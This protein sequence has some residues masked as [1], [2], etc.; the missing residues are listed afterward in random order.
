MSMYPLSFP[1][2]SGFGLYRGM[3]M[4][5]MGFMLR[6]LQEMFTVMGQSKYRLLEALYRQTPKFR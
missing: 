1:E 2:E 3:I 5:L 4:T 6:T